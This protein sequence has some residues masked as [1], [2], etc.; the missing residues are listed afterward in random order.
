[1]NC[2]ICDSSDVKVLLADV[3]GAQIFLCNNCH[4][5]FTWPTPQLPDYRTEDFQSKGKQDSTL[6]Q[7]H[8]LPR[9][10]LESYAIQSALVEKYLPT[11]AEILEIGGGEG[12]FLSMLRDKGY[13]VE[14]T[15][16]S[17]TAAARARERGLTVYNDYFQNV[18][19]KKE[20]AL[21]CLAHVLE[22]IDNPLRTLNALRLLLKPGG[23][24]LLTQTNFKGFMPVMQKN[25]WYAWVPDQHFFHFSISG[26]KF[27]AQKAGMEVMAYRYSRL[28][29]GQSIYNSAI[30]FIPRLQDQFHVM[31]KINK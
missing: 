4:N 16:P 22:H 15:E 10:I 8:E 29:H 14:L 6:T 24:I 27:L 5:A 20:Y 18:D 30:R 12:I 9:E 3:S 2:T 25:N 28:V 26:I 13:L 19:L 11:G 21:I 1:M 23:F 7:W 17:R 31:L